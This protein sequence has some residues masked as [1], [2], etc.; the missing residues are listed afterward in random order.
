MLKT[1]GLSFVE[2]VMDFH[3]QD[4][5]NS[6][7]IFPEETHLVALQ[8][9]ELPDE[10]VHEFRDLVHEER[11]TA[12]ASAVQHDGPPDRGVAVLHKHDLPG[13]SVMVVVIFTLSRSFLRSKGPSVC[14]LPSV[15]MRLEMIPRVV[16]S[17]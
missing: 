2:T 4:S 9:V 5:F 3:F 16:V 13:V 6:W 1:V 7:Y 15:W 8:C 14:T 11:Q 12:Q 17:S 10:T